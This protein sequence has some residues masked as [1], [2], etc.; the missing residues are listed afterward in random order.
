[1]TKTQFNAAV[2]IIRSDNCREYL[3]HSFQ[4]FLSEHGIL[5][6]TSCVDTPAQ[7]GVAERKKASSLSCLCT[8]FSDGCSSI[9]LE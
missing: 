9:L 1:M 5:H 2:K 8:S 3:V 6:Q 4:A 7:N